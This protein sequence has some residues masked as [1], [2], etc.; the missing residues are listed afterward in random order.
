MKNWR[1]GIFPILLAATS[2]AASAPQG[3][4]QAINNTTPFQV[5]ETSIVAIQAAYKAGKLTAH[6]LVQ[7]YLDRISAYD[8]QGPK[9]NAI[10]SLNPHALEMP[11]S[12]MRHIRNPD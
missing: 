8:K 12:W 4:G 2:L 6:Q 3:H 7:D 5:T 11:I 1:T 10:I 9:I